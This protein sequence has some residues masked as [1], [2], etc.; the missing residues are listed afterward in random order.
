MKQ[1]RLFVLFLFIVT[2]ASFSFAQGGNHHG[3]GYVNPD[4]LE[5]VMVEGYAIVDTTFMHPHY[6]LD[7]DNDGVEDYHLNFGPYWYEPDSSNASRPNDGDFITITGGL[8][9][10]NQINVPTIIVYEINGEFWR[11]PY[12]PFWNH[13][14]HNGAHG[15]HHMDS[16][17]TSGF[18]WQHDPPQTVTVSGSAL[19]DSTFIMVHYYLDEDNDNNPEYFLNFG[20]PWYEPQSG[21]P[22]PEDGDQIDIVGGLIENGTYSMIIVYEINGLEWR[23]SSFFGGHMGGGWIHRNMNQSHQFHSPFD[24]GDW[25]EMNPGWHTGGGHHGGMQ[26]SLF[27]QILETLPGSINTIGDENAFAG[28]EVQ[29][30]FARMMGG[31]GHGMNCG[32]HMEF[33]STANFQFSYTDAELQS[34]NI[35]ESTVQ[36]KYWDS[37]SNIWVAVTNVNHNNANNT[38]TFSNDVVGNFFILTGDSPTSVETSGDIIVEEFILKQNYP[39]PFNPATTIEFTVVKRSNVSLSVFN[40]LGQKVAD[41]VNENMEAGKYT[42]R[43]DASG[44]SSGVYIYKLRTDGT[45]LV[46]KMQLLK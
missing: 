31:M 28:Y 33:S 29:F 24:E 5:V 39:N 46:K 32:D 6:Y 36:V 27:C 42:V 43:F 16:C 15:G 13:M 25:M 1:L 45:S 8:N 4:S 14:G 20:P 22:R 44:L 34:K 41:L 23:D 3:G 11:D 40:L 26:D 30:F 18:G 9:D 12:N 38:V 2:A 35:V 21:A 17:H 7:E 10:H 19:V 37:H